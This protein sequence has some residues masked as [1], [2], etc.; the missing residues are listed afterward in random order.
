MAV[1]PNKYEKVCNGRGCGKRVGVGQ[2]F[3]Q[4]INGGWVTW[5]RD[6]CPERIAP[7]AARPAPQRVL[8]A[9]GHVI[10]PYEPDN[11][12][13]VRSF[14]GA[15]FHGNK[16]ICPVC[17]VRHPQPFWSVSLADADRE[18]VLQIADELRLDV[19]P[20]LRKV[21]V[22][23]QAQNATVAGLY[24]YQVTGVNWLAKQDFALLGDEMGMG[25]TIQTLVA[26]PAGARVLVVA[27]NG[28]KYNWRDETVKWRPDYNCVVVN[29]G[30]NF[31]TPRPGE[32]VVVN[33][34]CLP[35][36]LLPPKKR[37]GMKW[38]EAAR[39]LQA[40]YDILRSQHPDLC[41]CIVVVDEAHKVKGLDTQRGQKVCTLTH[42]CQKGWGLTG[43]PLLNKAMDLWGV[44]CNLNLDRRAF[45][46]AQGEWAFP[47]FK[48]AFNATKEYIRG[49]RREVLQWGAPTPEVPEKMRR[50]MLQRKRSAVLPDLPTKT[51]TEI[52]VSLEEVPGASAIKKELDGLWEEWG[53][54]MDV[55]EDLPPFTSFS[56]VREKL[57]RACIPAL[58]EYVE[59]CEEQEVGLVVASA[60]LA[61]LDALLGRDHWAVISGETPPED[62]QAICNQ[63]R[64]G[65]LQ[66]VGCSIT[67]AGV[68]LN[69]TGA[70]R[71]LF[72]DLDWVPANN[73]QM[74]DRIC[75]IGQT[76]NKCEIVRFV[77]DHPLCRHIHKLLAK[78]IALIAAAIDG[79]AQATVPTAK[80]VDGSQGESDAEYQARLE[81]ARQAELEY[82]RQQAE[83]QAAEAK[84]IGK[85]KAVVVLEREK[86]RA[87]GTTRCVLALTPERS[88]A[89]RRAFK[90]MLS[91]CDGAQAKDFQGFNK[92]DAVVAHC[93][94]HSGLE[95]PDELN[96]AYWML[97][98]YH[99]QLFEREPLLFT[100]NPQVYK[101]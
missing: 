18:R 25:K 21:V 11:L 101:K 79:K 33:Y 1:F 86:D 4:K 29:G 57:A 14:P 8:T 59:N 52:L 100:N 30:A 48:R 93:I 45:G 3:I 65:R 12:A 80:P 96:A 16:D 2:G 61:P 68:G 43:T 23:E 24:P 64:A 22:T 51:Y 17:N 91:V 28:L 60:H 94:L 63:Q 90:Y 34:E 85:A 74:E 71:M 97:T 88:E 55:K 82:D 15:R 47:N 26:L 95:E 83:R 35:D 36:F 31:R 58:L 39:Q 9:E 84:R 67:A 5:C 98:R 54:L 77:V 27:P 41:Q 38:D 6:C 32:I 20:S 62:R 46:N 92:P 40:H 42:I 53:T 44:L 66:G 76:A 13:L 99:R 72:V 78:K 7:V 10:T 75:R 89:V 70:S 49:A 37:K 87:A 73:W 69:L 56:L 50:V 81:R 19:A